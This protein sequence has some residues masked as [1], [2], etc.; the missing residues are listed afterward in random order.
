MSN[1]INCRL[2]FVCIFAILTQKEQKDSGIIDKETKIMSQHV[3]GLDMVAQAEVVE[4][5]EKVRDYEKE[6]KEYETKSEKQEK[7]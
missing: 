3:P 1:I 5:K 6:S 2:T 7:K 4:L